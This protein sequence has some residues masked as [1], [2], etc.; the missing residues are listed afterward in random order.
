MDIAK[1]ESPLCEGAGNLLKQH[2]RLR[3][4]DRHPDRFIL[5]TRKADHHHAPSNGMVF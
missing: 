4:S 1:F 5:S 2:F 3:R